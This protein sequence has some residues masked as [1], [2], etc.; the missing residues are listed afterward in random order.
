MSKNDSVTKTGFDIVE[1]AIPGAITGATIIGLAAA[2]I[3]GKVTKKTSLAATAN[4]SIDT[5]IKKSTDKISKYNISSKLEISSSN[6]ENTS[7]FCLFKIA[8][9]TN[10]VEVTVKLFQYTYFMDDSTRYINVDIMYYNSDNECIGNSSD[11][12]IMYSD[13]YDIVN[14]PDNFS[15]EICSSNYSIYNPLSNELTT[16]KFKIKL[17]E[18]HYVLTVNKKP[19]L[20]HTLTNGY[21]VYTYDSD[22]NRSITGC[23]LYTPSINYVR[24]II[25]Y[26]PGIYNFDVLESD[27]LLHHIEAE[28]E[29]INDCKNEIT[30]DVKYKF[31]YV[32][33]AE[34]V[35][36]NTV[37]IHHFLKI[38][39]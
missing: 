36:S 8:S 7:L 37:I 38:N 31:M 25:S 35:N 15:I 10:N 11:T 30:D 27:S 9:K 4:R 39:N 13:E 16:K 5:V 21:N 23:I 14:V 6:T 22:D 20:L 1:L 34:F 28:T 29:Y 33:K 32:K 17:P 2:G 19:N 3:A 12:N 24:P 18:T 26:I